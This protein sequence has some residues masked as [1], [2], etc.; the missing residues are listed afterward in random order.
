MGNLIP[1]D[2]MLKNFYYTYAAVNDK[3]QLADLEKS[4]IKKIG[5]ANLGVYRGGEPQ[6]YEHT[7]GGEENIKALLNKF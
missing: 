6:I 2:Y 1:L 4:V 7:N 3:N 5:K